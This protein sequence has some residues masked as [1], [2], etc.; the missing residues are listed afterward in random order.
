MLA[1]RRKKENEVKY[2]TKCNNKAKEIEQLIGCLIIRARD[3]LRQSGWPAASWLLLLNLS[4]Y[5]YKSY[6]NT[7]DTGLLSNN[8]ISR[9]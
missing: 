4:V 2:T 7:F 9:C 3:S 1:E 8:I 5:L 6:L